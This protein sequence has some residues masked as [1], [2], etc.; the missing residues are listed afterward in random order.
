MVKN[1]RGEAKNAEGDE[2]DTYWDKILVCSHLDVSARDKRSVPRSGT[3][4]VWSKV[5]RWHGCYVVRS[6]FAFTDYAFRLFHSASRLRRPPGRILREIK[7]KEWIKRNSR[8][9]TAYQR[10]IPAKNCEDKT[11][12]VLNRHLEYVWLVTL[13]LPPITENCIQR[14]F[15]WTVLVDISIWT[16]F[17]LVAQNSRRNRENLDRGYI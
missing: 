12:S 8:A 3:F 16:L 6:V 5:S 15:R 1:T 7:V 13:S 9:T 11:S 4:L 17:L 2:E 10:A 14:Y